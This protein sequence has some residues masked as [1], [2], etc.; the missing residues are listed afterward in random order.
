M[1]GFAVEIGPAQM[2]EIRVT[3][4]SMQGEDHDPLQF[5]RGVF[6]EFC[7]VMIGPDDVSA[8]DLCSR[9]KCAIGLTVILP[10]SCA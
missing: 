10:L 5:D 6:H 4:T 9:L 1:Q 8:V 7:D 3:L 2:D